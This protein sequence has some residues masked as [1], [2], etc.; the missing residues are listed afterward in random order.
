MKGF[1]LVVRQY[2][3]NNEFELSIEAIDPTRYRG[4][5]LGGDCPWSIH[6][7]PI[8]KGVAIVQVIVFNDIHTC[9]SSGRR[10]ITPTIAWAAAKAFLFLGRNLIWVLKSYR[11]NCRMIMDVSLDMTRSGGDNKGLCKSCM[12]HG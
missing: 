3:I 10:T 9:T 12:A 7:C 11:P 1:R 2:V 6:A 5:C 8:R 4:F